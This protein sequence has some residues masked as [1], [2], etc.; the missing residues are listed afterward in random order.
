MKTYSKIIMLI[1]FLSLLPLSALQAESIKDNTYL[2]FVWTPAGSPLIP[3]WADQFEFD[4]GDVYRAYTT[5]KG[6]F[7]GTWIETELIELPNTSL[8]WFQAYVLRSEESTTTT[9]T[10]STTTITI[11]NFRGFQESLVTPQQVKYDINIWGIASTY[12]IELPDT[13]PFDDIVPTIGFSLMM[14]YGNYLGADARF[15]GIASVQGG[16][17]GGG[18]PAFGSI[19]PEEGVQETTLTSVEITGE[20]T[21]FRDDGVNAIIFSP[22][23]GLTITNITVQDNTT[24]EFDLMISVSAS[25]GPRSVIV[26]YDNFTKVITGESVFE[27]LP[28]P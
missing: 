8:T 4:A 9:T 3:R 6:L 14:G 16:G 13:N 18:T 22:D 7:T 28:K 5:T 25:T 20:N 11:P 24:V 17:G 23:D 19:S 12:T 2:V 1:L 27:V 10:P 26:T 15:V 21:T